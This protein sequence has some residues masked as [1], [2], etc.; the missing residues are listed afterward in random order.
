M[1]IQLSPT[2]LAAWGTGIAAAAGAA[3]GAVGVL[4]RRWSSDGAAVS[5]DKV[6]S[7]FLG[8]AMDERDEALRIIRETQAQRAAE[9]ELVATLRAHIRF[10]ESAAARHAME[11]D[12]F[13]RRV[14]RLYPET[15]QFVDSSL[16]PLP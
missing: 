11:F 3:G 13:K 15:R 5:R 14:V 6:E 16:A 9:L 2:E 7:R 4:R 12:A 1:P 10:L 8:Q